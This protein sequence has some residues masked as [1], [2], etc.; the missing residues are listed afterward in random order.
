MLFLDYLSDH[1]FL[2]FVRL[3]SGFGS[4]DDSQEILTLYCHF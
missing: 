3:C 1:T 2:T 4:L